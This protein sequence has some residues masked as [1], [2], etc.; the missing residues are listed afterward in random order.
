MR[1]RPQAAALAVAIATALILGG[2][3]EAAP[4]A[5]PT[6]QPL[7]GPVFA[8][9]ADAVAAAL[10]AYMAYVAMSDTVMSEGGRNPGRMLSVETPEQYRQDATDIATVSRNHWHTTGSTSID[11]VLLQDYE[12]SAADG[13]AIVTIYACV[14]V[15]NLDVLDSQGNSVASP[16]RALTSTYLTVFD[17][18]SRNP[19]RLVVAD[20]ALWQGDSI[21]NR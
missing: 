8:S 9:R 14:D 4:K 12:P 15:R 6:V 20:Q 7:A 21:C 5:R 17:V 10:K 2:C 19:A 3:T 11:S 16:S 18:A 1:T 13:R